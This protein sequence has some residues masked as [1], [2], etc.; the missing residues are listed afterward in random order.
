MVQTTTSA[1]VFQIGYIMF[2]DMGNKMYT[3]V[4]EQNVQVPEVRWLSV[5]HKGDVVECIVAMGFIYQISGSTNK[6]LEG[7]M[8][9]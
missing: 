5:K 8:E 1:G 2:E 4:L 7:V 3:R 6:V 9:L